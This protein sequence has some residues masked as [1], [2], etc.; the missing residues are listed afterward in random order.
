MTRFTQSKK[1]MNQPPNL[2]APVAE[3]T[4]EVNGL[5]CEE[6]KSAND[7]GDKTKTKTKTLDVNG[8]T[9]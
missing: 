3:M 4:F 2:S 9:L 5:H 6:G 1:N 8:F 7:E